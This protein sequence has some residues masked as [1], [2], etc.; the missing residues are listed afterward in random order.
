MK[1]PRCRAV[2]KDNV[3]GCPE[4]GYKEVEEFS[5]TNI[6]K[7][8]HLG[9]KKDDILPDGY[10]RH[11]YHH[12]GKRGLFAIF[13]LYKNIIKFNG[14]SDWIEYWTQSLYIFIPCFIFFE[15]R[16][17][18]ILAQ[19]NPSST[20]TIMYFISMGFLMITLLAYAT[21]KIR[22][23]RDAGFSPLFIFLG[24]VGDILTLFK[25]NRNEHNRAYEKKPTIKVKLED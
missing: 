16:D 24:V 22:R 12:D 5:G 9:N 7:L 1:C 19:L 4:C 25:Y 13:A 15:I 2:I 14:V 18:M 6:G 11:Y 20:L 8:S 3:N 17:R 23:L 21:A 10:P